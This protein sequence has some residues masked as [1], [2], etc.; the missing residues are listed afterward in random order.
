LKEEYL[1]SVWLFVLLMGILL[2]ALVLILLWHPQRSRTTS[3]IPDNRQFTDNIYRDDERYWVGGF[4]YNNPDDPA[5]FVP[6][7]FGLGWTVNFGNP[8][9]ML[10]FICMLLIP[11]VLAILGVL[12]SG[13]TPMGCH[14]FGC[15]P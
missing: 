13:G 15:T 9:G 7:R 3:N 4:F 8:K 5:M 14:T 6:K 2:I 12:F 10:F 11:L 1:M